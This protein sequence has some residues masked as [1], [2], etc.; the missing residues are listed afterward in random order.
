MRGEGVDARAPVL[1]VESAHVHRACIAHSERCPHVDESREHQARAAAHWR[2]AVQLLADEDLTRVD[3]NNNNG[4]GGRGCKGGEAA[5]AVRSSLSN[6][7]LAT[8]SAAAQDACRTPLSHPARLKRG[9]TI[10]K[11]DARPP[12]WTSSP[13]MG[14][15]V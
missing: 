9:A 13:T 8:R 6:N 4:S 1:R 5:V 10:L 3:N 7:A 2:G 12:G 14:A 15:A 11:N